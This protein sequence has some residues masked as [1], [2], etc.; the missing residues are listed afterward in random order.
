MTAETIRHLTA[1]A[2]AF[3]DWAAPEPLIGRIEPEPYPVDALPPTIRAAV[4]EVVGFVQAPVAIAAASAL[5]AVSVAAQAA[6]GVR[7]T[8]G[9]E[10]PVSLF[11]LTIADSGE[12]KSTCDGY[13]TSAI[14]EYEREAADLAR[15]DI[16]AHAAALAAWEAK[17]SGLTGAI[18]QGAKGGKDT[19]EHEERL[20]DLESEKP[21]PPLVPRLLYG[22]VTPEALA[23]GLAMGWPSGGVMS[24]E[25]G[26]VLGGHAMGKDS[27]M[28]NL[29]LLN[30]LWDGGRLPIDR[31]TGASFVV[32]GAR[33]SVGLM[34][35]ETALRSFFERDGGLSR[36]TGFLAR[37]LMAQPMSTQGHRL[38]AEPPAGW[39]ALT[40][41]HRRIAAILREPMPFNEGRLEPP[42]LDLAPDAK[43]AWVDFFNAVE[44]ELRDG[45]DL[46][47]IRDVAS[48][49]A[50]NAARLAALFQMIEHGPSPIGVDALRRGCMIAAWHLTE[51]R[52]FFGE[53]AL[54]PEIM[55]AVILDRWLV[56]HCRREAVGAI[57]ARTAMNIGPNRLRKRDA[58]AAAVKEL[59]Q[60]GRVRLRGTRPA[61]IEVN[62]ALLEGGA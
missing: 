8:S 13:F 17:R 16:A 39:P 18:T 26:V 46:R 5:S 44:V 19:R 62:P 10:G 42:A 57:P 47:E 61:M 25:A 20:A 53:L 27:A 55:G 11:M 23:Y 3:G 14:Q 48:K 2:P 36:G 43:A 32:D 41:F 51:A 28:R 50:D 60:A 59:E 1:I 24:S 9:L 12:R 37:F 49:T 7:R 4:A 58:L 52:R 33:L 40:A 30:V 15:P 6:V 31:R 45:G 54:P 38:F 35:Q 29:A 21:V 22:D 34:I 56:E